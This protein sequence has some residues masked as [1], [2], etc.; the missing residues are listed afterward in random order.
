MKAVSLNT[1]DKMTIK[2]YFSKEQ[3]INN[4]VVDEIFYK[5]TQTINFNES[6]KRYAQIEIAHIDTNTWAFGWEISDGFNNRVLKR[7]CTT[8]I[9]TKGPIDKLVYGMT[10]V[11]QRQLN[12]L[13]FPTRSI[14]KLIDEAIE[15]ASTYCK[16]N[17]T[18]TGK[19]T[20]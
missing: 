20:I 7:D 5:N 10:K 11:L 18:D 8:R 1:I 19:I 4:E 14:V 12:L 13:T 16:C 9:T 2:E 15:E 17:H 3:P 6:G